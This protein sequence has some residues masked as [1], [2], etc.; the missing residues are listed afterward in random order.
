QSAAGGRQEG[1]RREEPGPVEP[2]RRDAVG[3]G[4]VVA[5]AVVAAAGIG[6]AVYGAIADGQAHDQTT[7]AD[8]ATREDLESRANVTGVAGYVAI[9][10]GVAALVGGV[11]KLAVKPR[12]AATV[13]LDVGS[14]RAGISFAGRF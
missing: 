7:R 8:L 9:G 6:L 1:E 2:S 14:G 10:V 3:L 5:G 11:I 13:G 4:L 12:A